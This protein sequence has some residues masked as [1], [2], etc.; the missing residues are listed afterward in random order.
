MA[1]EP[2]SARCRACGGELLLREV[3]DS[4]SGRSPSCGE[5]L[6]PGYTFLLLEEARR[7]E[8]LQRALVLCLQR[9][10]DLPGHVELDRS[11]CSAT[12]WP[13]SGGTSVSRTTGR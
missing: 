4:T 1:I 12:R 10:V 9:L 7:A 13:R 5:L 2:L 8:A 11:R 3:A 6:A